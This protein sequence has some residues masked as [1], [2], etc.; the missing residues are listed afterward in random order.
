M[1]DNKWKKVQVIGGATITLCD[2][3]SGGSRSDAW[4]GADWGP[5]G[6]IIFGTV[7]KGLSKV[8]AAAGAPKVVTTLDAKRGDRAHRWPQILPGGQSVLSRRASSAS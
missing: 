6:T 4:S 3:S 2:A 8:S 1:Q 7:D 5:D